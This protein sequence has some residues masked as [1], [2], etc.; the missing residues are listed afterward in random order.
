MEKVF[1]AF[2]RW[3]CL[4]GLERPGHYR[5]KCCS[6]LLAQFRIGAVKGNTL[7]W[8]VPERIVSFSNRI[9]TM[10]RNC[11]SRRFNH[12]GRKPCCSF[13]AESWTY[14]NAKTKYHNQV[15]PDVF[16]L[17]TISIIAHSSWVFTEDGTLQSCQLPFP[18]AGTI[19]G[20]VLA[21]GFLCISQ[22]GLPRDLLVYFIGIAS[23]RPR[24]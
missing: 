5:W 8:V 1:P 20:I 9:R 19:E 6:S 10:L 14:V 4:I 13:I 16:F 23:T 2:A 3:K 12:G 11:L 24:L 15:I 21:G 18:N 17:N 7:L 22:I